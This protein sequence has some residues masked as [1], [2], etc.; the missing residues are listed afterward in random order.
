MLLGLWTGCAEEACR[1][2]TRETVELMGSSFLVD[3][4]PDETSEIELTTH[5]SGSGRVEQFIYLMQAEEPHF[6][7][8]VTLDEIVLGRNEIDPARATLQ[9]Y[10]DAYEPVWSTA[11]TGQL[12]VSTLS[13]RRCEQS[14][15]PDNHG[16]A[17]ALD[18]TAAWELEAM[19]DRFYRLSLAFAVDQELTSY[20]YE[21]DGL[22]GCDY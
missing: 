4:G 9:A 3:A 14:S 20:C 5:A 17:C 18:V 22:E 1:W 11:V 16:W 21:C 7:I 13:E 2:D 12:T 10:R 6:V 15:E 19:H 8:H